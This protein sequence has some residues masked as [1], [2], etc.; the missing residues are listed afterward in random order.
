MYVGLLEEHINEILTDQTTAVICSIGDRASLGASILQRK[1][2]TDIHVVLGGMF[3]WQNAG[4][5]ITRS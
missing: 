1:G 2:Y 3:A 5:S 4:Y